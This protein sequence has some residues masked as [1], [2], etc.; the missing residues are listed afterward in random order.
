M[1]SRLFWKL[2]GIQLL[3][4][5]LLLSGALAVMRWN[6]AHN[7]SAYLDA[8]RRGNIKADADRIAHAY[9]RLHDL[10]AAA[11]SIPRIGGEPPRPREFSGRPGPD[12]Q[13]P[14]GP[15]GPPP[16]EDQRRGRLPLQVQAPDH[17]I[18][19]GSRRPIPEDDIWR[20]PIIVGGETVGYLAQPVLGFKPVIAEDVFL[21][22]QTRGLWLIGGVSMLLATIVA[23]FVATIVLRP[24]RRLSTAAAALADRRFDTQLP[25]DRDDE[26]GQLAEDFNCLATSLAQYDQR[27]KQW[28]ADIAHE[29]RT[30][31][32]V[33][34]GELEAVID[35]IRQ[36]E[37]AT[38]RSL[39]QEVQ[40]L[41]KLVDD[42]HLLSVAEGGGL[43]IRPAQLDVEGVVDDSFTRFRE[44]F[45][46]RGFV[47]EKRI[48][49][50]GL[51]VRADRQRIEQVVANLLENAL[52][53][54][55][56]PGP[57][58]LS[59]GKAAGGIALRVS[60]G[61]P[62]VPAEAL[63]RLF[64]RLYRVDASRSRASG[65]S[66]LGL[67]I[68]RSIAEAHGGTLTARKSVRGG[69]EVEL[70]LPQDRGSPA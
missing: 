31:L 35:G 20:E 64:D 11:N 69:L 38:I 37:P 17:R 36:A 55:D 60:D 16:E 28:I 56:P 2:L 1:R 34:R 47:L 39:H 23:A 52:R 30:P 6:T 51:R 32:A 25:I 67:A 49:A 12:F 3:A 45:Q 8:T 66:G 59:A 46:Q 29:L 40:R 50:K 43:Q 41:S 62:G 21:H 10:T 22:A 58:I 54:A 57:V 61:G 7:F 68:C 53:H 27:Q 18:V 15:P 19:A 70:I 42:L 13:P 26:I 24:L 65:G 5:G 44:R 33:L 9:E 63:P 48:D 4:F 14:D